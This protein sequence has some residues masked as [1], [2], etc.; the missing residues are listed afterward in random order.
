M[1]G[2]S[3]GIDGRHTRWC[4]HHHAFGAAL[5]EGFQEGGLARACFTRK[6]DAVTCVFHK[7]PCC[8]HLFVDF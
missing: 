6:E 4:H 8:S 2:H 1:D 5:Y 7:V 3:T